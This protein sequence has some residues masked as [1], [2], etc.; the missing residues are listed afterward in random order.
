MRIQGELKSIDLVK[1]AF[2]EIL[3]TLT[4]N[5]ESSKGSSITPKIKHF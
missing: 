5:G 3:K 4:I 2:L 1:F